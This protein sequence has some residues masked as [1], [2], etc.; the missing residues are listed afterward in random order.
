MRRMIGTAMLCG[1]AFA[2]LG[3]AAER[4]A[5]AC[6]EPQP[7]CGDLTNPA[8]PTQRVHVQQA[9][10]Y[11]PQKPNCGCVSALANLAGKVTK[12]AIFDAAGKAVPGFCD[13]QDS[14]LAAGLL[15]GAFPSLAINNASLA[16][17][18]QAGFWSGTAY[19]AQL[20]EES[21]GDDPGAFVTAELDFDEEGNATINNEHQGEI[22]VNN[23]D[24]CGPDSTSVVCTIA[25]QALEQFNGPQTVARTACAQTDAAVLLGVA[26]ESE[27]GGC[28][29]PGGRGA[30][31]GLLF[32]IAGLA[33]AIRRVRRS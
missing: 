13:V 17:I 3:L 18:S 6:G 15:Q 11:P 2:A 26:P 33:Y 12:T 7:T 16:A 32:V 27:A 20:I 4:S 25:T 28:S 8:N 24:Q 22:A 10:L 5:D 23:C 19:F 1:L 14:P 30:A 21:N 9:G 31:G 29:V